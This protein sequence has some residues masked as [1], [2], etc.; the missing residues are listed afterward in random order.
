MT[1]NAMGTYIVKETPGGKPTLI[2][3][4]SRE[5]RIHSAYEPDREAE[6]AVEGFSAGRAT[7]IAVSG[8]GLGY[9]LDSLRRR[10]PGRPVIAVE[11]DPEVAELARKTCPRH[12]EGVT[13]VFSGADLSAVFEAVDMAGFRGIAHYIHRPSYQLNRDFYDAVFR[14]MNQYATSKISD[15]LTRFEFEERWVE[16]IL[17]NAARLFDSTRVRDLFGAFAGCPGVIISAGP[18]LRGNIRFLADM[19]D[20]AL[21]VAVDTAV[22]VLRKRG[23]VPHLVMTLDAQKYSIKHFMGL[24][25][26]AAALVADLVCYPPVMRSYRGPRI[27]STTSKYYTSAGGELKREMT[28]LMEWVEGLA[29]P[30]GDIQSGGSVATSAFDLLL[31]LGCSPI[32]L[33]GQDLAYTGREIHCS[34]THHNDEWLPRYTRF[35]NLDTINQNVV[36]RRKIKYVPAYGGAGTVIS[37]F[38]FDLYRGWFE[39]SAGKVKV[40]VINATGGGARI[41]NTE[42][43]PLS[44]LAERYP[45]RTPSPGE[46]LSRAL[47]SAKPGSP[48]GLIRGMEAAI[49]ELGGIRG[50]AESA[51]GDRERVRAVE[52]MANSPVLRPV[53]QPFLRKAHT[54]LARYN[55]SPEEAERLLLKDIIAAAEKLVP[56]LEKSSRELSGI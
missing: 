53:L 1:A 44:S 8:I 16:N 55:A 19:R 6:R 38:V 10:F 48:D 34:G 42:E 32:I 15:L 3:R 17:G 12:L 33:V 28:P 46:A 14:D 40:P 23:I 20:R 39:D 35:Y 21:M 52:E 30:V 37:D 5:V 54:F 31:N 43:C 25:E 49:R 7:M 18:S 11:H 56:L 24:R 2:Y 26:S 41:A 51:L 4:N 29:G 47:S 13:V 45:V 36:R 22:P 9:H 27:V 50:A